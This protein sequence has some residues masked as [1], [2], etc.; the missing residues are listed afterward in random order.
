[1]L[2][3]H[4]AQI[5][6][7]IREAGFDIASFTFCDLPDPYV[8]TNGFFSKLD[9]KMGEY[10]YT[11]EKGER[12]FQ[13][14]MSPGLAC[15]AERKYFEN[16]SEQITFIRFWLRLLK[17]EIETDDPW[18]EFVGKSE[19][20]ASTFI[21]SIDEEMFTDDEKASIRRTLADVKKEIATAFD[22]SPEEA[23]AVGEK[24]NYVD[25]ALDRLNRFDWRSV[26]TGVITNIATTLAFSHEARSTL[27][28]LFKAAFSG[29]RHLTG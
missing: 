20:D 9:Y 27:F 28:A 6:A 10:F 14:V 1:M 25:E 13:S 19:S 24:L 5:A 12:G 23:A 29:M 17:Q 11:F 8:K 22:L 7:H 16:R 3:N 26:A 18:D 4:K 15:R 2:K 21:G